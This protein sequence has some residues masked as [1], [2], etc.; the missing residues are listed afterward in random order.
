MKGLSEG[1]GSL[2]VLKDELRRN[3]YRF[4]RG[5]R[6]AVTRKE[7][8]RE[9]GISTKLAA[10]HLDQLVDRGFLRFH[11]A[12]PPGRSGPGAGRTSKY[13]E[14]SDLE[15]EVSIPQREYQLVGRLLLNALQTQQPGETPRDAV[16][17]VA[18]E[19]GRELAQE[20]RETVGRRRIGPERALSSIQTV[21]EEHGYEPYEAA[22]GEIRLKNCPFHHLSAD[23]PDWICGMNQ[24]FIEGMVRGL[25]NE[26]LEVALEPSAPE[27]CV[28]LRLPSQG[29]GQPEA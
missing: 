5:S 10:F 22:K 12:R 25:G 29:K 11:Y 13:Y 14:P 19:A 21:L 1:A 2:A 3:I 16:L 8:A 6:R 27:C 17:R 24:A 26:S 4:V 28:R 23:A 20:L 15:I 9:A 18:D 7:V